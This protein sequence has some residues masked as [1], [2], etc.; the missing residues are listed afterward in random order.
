PLWLFRCASEDTD[1]KLTLIL[2][3][4]GLQAIPQDKPLTIRGEVDF[5]EVPVIVQRSGKHVG[6]LKKEN[7]TLQQDGKTQPIATFEEIHAG[8][9]A[10]GAKADSSDNSQ[11][12][13]PQFTI[14]ALDTVNTPT[15]DRAYFEKEFQKYLTA[16]GTLKTSTGLVVIERTGIRV[17]CGFT[18]NAKALLTA[19]QYANKM[20]PT[21]NSDP[22]KLAQQ[23]SDEQPA[24]AGDPDSGRLA[25]ATDVLR[26]A[27]E[28]MVRFQDRAAKM[29]SLFTIQQL[30]QAL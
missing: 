21:K 17:L 23:L 13:I 11:L 27:D 28:R 20:P 26:A 16:V 4:A 15:L 19:M 29:D 9:A 10:G 14:I 18:T 1:V 12:D 8:P 5:A 2:L 6:G 3:A 30:A 22:N 24:S 25:A 7:F